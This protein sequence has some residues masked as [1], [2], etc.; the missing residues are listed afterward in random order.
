MKKL[1]LI[2]TAAA[3]CLSLFSCSRSVIGKWR[4]ENSVILIFSRDGVLT[5]T[6]PDDDSAIEYNFS[7]EINDGVITVGG[8][9]QLSA[10][11]PEFI[12]LNGATCSIE[13]KTLRLTYSGQEYILEKVR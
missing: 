3:L 4:Y 9:S 12:P 2:L 1:F 10:L 5:V 13:G 11:M 6:T 7:Y 8:A